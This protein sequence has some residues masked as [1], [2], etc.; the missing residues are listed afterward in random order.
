MTVCFL[1]GTRPGTAPGDRKFRPDVQGLRAVA[2]LL[3]VLFHAGVPGVSGGYVGVDVFFV[4]SGF[5]ITGVLLRER[6]SNGSTSILAFYGRRARRIIPAATLVI[7]ATVLGARWFLDPLSAGETAVDGQ[8]ASVFLANF[9]FAASGSQLSRF[10]QATLTTT[11]LLV[12]GRR[13]TILHRVPDDLLDRGRDHRSPV[14]EDSARRRSRPHHV[15]VI[16]AL[17]RHDLGE[18]VG[19]VLLPPHTG[20]GTCLGRSGG[21]V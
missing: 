16:C 12:A 8:W 3:V 13:R 9:H 7:L 18:P 15:G 2:I 6:A 19:C 5:V 4:I 17:D 20:L 21:P 11:E 14:A 1:L 10:A